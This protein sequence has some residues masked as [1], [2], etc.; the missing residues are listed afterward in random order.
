MTT[1]NDPNRGPNGQE[2]SDDEVALG[3]KTQRLVNL[4]TLI[5]IGILLVI[6]AYVLTQVPFTTTIIYNRLSSEFRLP[7]LALLALPA[8]LTFGWF[9]SR[10]PES[11]KMPTKERYVLI[12]FSSAFIA[13]SLF[14]QVR[15]ALAFLEA[16]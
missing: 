12:T 11:E 5:T 13:F 7:L 15:F 4:A 10:G 16:G 1:S 2:L 3:K 14:A 9:R 6:F 8:L